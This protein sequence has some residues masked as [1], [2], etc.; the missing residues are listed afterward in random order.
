[1]K[2]NIVAPIG[3]ILILAGGIALSVYTATN[4]PVLEQTKDKLVTKYVNMS[5]KALAK[6]DLKE[7]EKIIKKAI[8]ANPASKTALNEY[9]KIILASC[10]KTVV[11]TPS[12]SQADS[13]P[14]ADAKAQPTQT[15]QPVQPATDDSEEEM[16]C[17]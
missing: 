14:K 11:A 1:M 3:G 6:G 5:E 13:T 4:A 9:K 17:I 12:A 2:T 15:A 16:G 7:A 10:P 8:I